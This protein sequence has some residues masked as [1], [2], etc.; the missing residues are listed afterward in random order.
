MLM[1][2]LFNILFMKIAVFSMNNEAGYLYCTV[3]G[4]CI[5]FLDKFICAVSY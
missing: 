5:L 2:F 4:T 1:S 3:F